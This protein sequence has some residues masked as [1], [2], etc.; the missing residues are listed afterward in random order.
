MLHTSVTTAVFRL[1]G[2]RP[3]IGFPIPPRTRFISPRLASLCATISHATSDISPRKSINN[4]WE[5]QDNQSFLSPRQ[6]LYWSYGPDQLGLPTVPSFPSSTS[7]LD[8][9]TSFISAFSISPVGWLDLGLYLANSTNPICIL[10]CAHLYTGLRYQPVE[11]K[12]STLGW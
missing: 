5:S 12:S 8:V 3:L 1:H 2:G 9:C 10:F 4:F 6:S 11:G 7:S